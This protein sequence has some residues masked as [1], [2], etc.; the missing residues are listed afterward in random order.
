MGRNLYYGFILSGGL[1]MT[2]PMALG[3]IDPSGNSAYASNAQMP[4][5]GQQAASHAQQSGMEQESTAARTDPQTMKD[6]IFL[7][8][9]AEGGTAEEEL[10]KLA[11]SKTSNDE[12]KQFAQKMLDDHASLDVTMKPIAQSLGVMTPKK[13]NKEDQ[14]EFEKLKALSGTDFDKEYLGA[15]I[16]DHRMDLHEFRQESATATDPALKDAATSGSKV[17]HDHLVAAYKL[18]VANGVEVPRMPKPEPAS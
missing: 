11:L 6:K 7:R 16:K 17:I 4:T 8:K 10:A 15:M 1:L 9:A 5:P 14:A 3:Q 13:M 12:V 18:G 2:A